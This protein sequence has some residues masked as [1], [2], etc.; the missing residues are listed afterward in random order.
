MKGSTKETLYRGGRKEGRAEGLRDTSG[1]VDGPD[2]GTSLERLKGREP[3]CF[4][5]RESQL[6]YKREQSSTP[7]EELLLSPLLQSTPSW[8]SCVRGAP[9]SS[10]RGKRE[11]QEVVDRRAGRL[12]RREPCGGRSAPSRSE[13]P[14]LRRGGLPPQPPFRE[15]GR[16]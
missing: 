4:K 8:E 1:R 14:S 2:P 13:A 7:S 5:G 3:R 15:E 12:Q 11:F 10:H 9:C 6:V 16:K